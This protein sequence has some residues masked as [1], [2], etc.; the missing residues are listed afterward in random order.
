MEHASVMPSDN[1]WRVLRV[2][3]ARA[4]D[5]G[6]VSGCPRSPG[7]N[8]MMFRMSLSEIA[9]AAGVTPATAYKHVRRL[10]RRG[11]IRRESRPGPTPATIYMTSV[12]FRILEDAIGLLTMWG[13]RQPPE[14]GERPSV[15][16]SGFGENCK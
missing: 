2:I 5:L 6:G 16:R 9:G 8:E 12:V 13:E 1:D 3:I 14:W 4:R 15:G 7:S 11:L 10:A